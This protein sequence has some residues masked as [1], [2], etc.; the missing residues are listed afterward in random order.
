[1]VSKHLK[2]R[3]G[4]GAGNLRS[5]TVAEQTLLLLQLLDLILICGLA[6]E[7]VDVT[8]RTLSRD[9]ESSV[10]LSNT[11]PTDTQRGGVT[12]ARTLVCTGS[13]V[14]HV[15]RS[16][17]PTLAGL[18]RHG[19]STRGGKGHAA[20]GG[21][22][23]EVDGTHGADSTASEG[24]RRVAVELTRE[25]VIESG[26][27]ARTRFSR[28]G[29]GSVMPVG[30]GRRSSR[31]SGMRC[32]Q[33]HERVGGGGIKHGMPDLRVVTRVRGR[34]IVGPDRIPMRE[35]VLVIRRRATMIGNRGR[36]FWRSRG[37]EDLIIQHTH[38]VLFG[39]G[40]FCLEGCGRLLVKVEGRWLRIP[41]H[42]FQSQQ[43]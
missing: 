20:V 35:G 4:W 26:R 41:G 5:L 15:S 42:L 43:E 27:G 31:S 23:G 37:I 34:G 16:R 17:H 18:G 36:Q 13:S 30:G 39:K 6:D 1:M 32:V 29:P 7:V 12:V 11:I 38:L 28:Q 22:G 9:L 21:H 8:Q 33:T 2:R 40:R 14:G 3:G 10:L 24:G 19:N 25:V